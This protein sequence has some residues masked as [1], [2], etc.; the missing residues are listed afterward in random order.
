[1]GVELENISY[2]VLIK[3]NVKNPYHRWIYEIGY[4]GQG[5]HKSCN[6]NTGCD[7]TMYEKW[8]SMFQRCYSKRCLIKI[9]TYIECS[10]SDLWHNFQNF[11]D[12]FENNYVKGWHL[13]KDILVKGNKIYSPETCA[14]VPQEINMLFTKRD[15][16]RGEYPIGVS[17]I[18]KRYA[19]KIR[20]NGILTNMGTFNTPE[21]AFQ[22]Y[23]TA[24]ES[25]I[26]EVADK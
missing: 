10:V 13:D 4:M 22:A 7:N 21:E 26:K 3:G 12:W 8:Q 19:S 2:L 18:K 15:S 1:M 24:K 17:K 11:G 16:K 23:K 6:K 5:S 25:H 20:K 14:F 9:P